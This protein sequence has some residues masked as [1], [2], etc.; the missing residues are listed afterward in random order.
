[1]EAES[2]SRKRRV[3]EED[4]EESKRRRIEG[5]AVDPAVELSGSEVKQGPSDG[6]LVSFMYT[7]GS[8]FPD[9][10]KYIG[11]TIE[12]R[13]PSVFLSSRN[14]EVVTRQIWGTDVYTDD[15]DVLASKI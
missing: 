6:P 7:P 12:V 5:A 8:S 14:R 1:M 2:A 13:I 9:L 15:S 3:R 4:T 10:R 11:G